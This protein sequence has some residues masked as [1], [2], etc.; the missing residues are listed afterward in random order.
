MKELEKGL[1][2][3]RRYIAET[4]IQGMDIQD[5]FQELQQTNWD[6][7]VNEAKLREWPIIACVRCSHNT[8]VNMRNISLQ[9]H[10]CDECAK[11]EKEITPSLCKEC[12]ETHTSQD[13]A[14]I[15]IPTNTTRHTRTVRS[16]PNKIEETTDRY[17]IN[18]MRCNNRYL[19]FI[20]KRLC[21]DCYTS[22]YI[23]EA[24]RVSAHNQRVKE[25]KLESGL[26][27]SQWLA[28]LDYFEWKCAYCKRGFAGIEHF[29]PISLN[30]GTTA[31]N[32]LPSC[33]N[34]NHRKHDRHPDQLDS[35][36]P[37][38]N[39]ARIRQYLS[40]QSA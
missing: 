23:K 36:F 8:I 31:N 37:A 5:I 20:S 25:L 16:C 19:P 17:K 10:L 38:E 22:K 14:E 2:M 13:L 7:W 9:G 3:I 39:L 32:C 4:S 18:C 24:D 15:K 33:Q 28:T 29:L 11:Q 1:N 12:G 26:T 35:I 6:E 30:G 40:E 21:D 27:L 34:C